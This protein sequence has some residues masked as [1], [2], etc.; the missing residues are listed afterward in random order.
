MKRRFFCF[1]ALLV[2]GLAGFVPVQAAQPFE[3]PAVF[4][5]GG[6]SMEFEISFDFGL[7]GD[8]ELTL[9]SNPAPV[10]GFIDIDSISTLT[11]VSRGRMRDISASTGAE[12]SALGEEL[13]F[14]ITAALSADPLDGT[15][16][17]GENRAVFNSDNLVLTLSIDSESFDPESWEIPL[18]GTPLPAEYSDGILGIDANLEFS[19]EYEGFEFSADIGLYL[20]GVLQGQGAEDGKLTLDLELDKS[21][22]QTGDRLRLRVG[23]EN[24]GG[25]RQVD[26][27]VAFF[28]HEGN[29]FFAPDYTGTMT[30]LTRVNLVAGQSVALTEI[31][32]V[33]LPA[34]SPPIAAAGACSFCAVITNAGGREPISN[35]ACADFIY[36]TSLQSE[37]APFDGEW[38]GSGGSSAPGGECPPAAAVHMTIVESQIR[39]SADE[40]V[41]VDADGYRMTG[42]ID[43]SGEIVD[44]ILLEEYMNSWIPVGS[45]T[46][47]F[48]G[49]TCSGTWMDEYGCY[50]AFTLEKMN[51]E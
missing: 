19:E 45:F 28:D 51:Q 1:L 18:S 34:H 44:G 36:D 2:M 40:L 42:T 9:D 49:T 37:T 14:T 23:L 15:F 11:G 43:V 22:Y 16:F 20:R 5:F 4:D 47:T 50:G 26:I 46:G 24:G 30:P 39:G 7:A 41:E 3:A 10:T 29:Y 25:E 38:H 6:S 35:L 17:W 27:Y 32:D 31:I 12:M 13:E 8:Y 33:C 48:F 21:I